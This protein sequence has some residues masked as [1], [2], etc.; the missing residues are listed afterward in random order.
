MNDAGGVN[1]IAEKIHSIGLKLQKQLQAIEGI[2]IYYPGTR[3]GI[4]TFRTSQL[5]PEKLK[6][7]LWEADNFGNQFE[8]SVV[9]ATSTPLD[10]A[11]TKVRNL[12]RASVSYTTTQREVL[13]FCERLQQILGETV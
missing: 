3:S 1:A 12:V 10:A 11:R 4:I 6:E 5:E 8:V 13:K 2:E 9:P 7:H